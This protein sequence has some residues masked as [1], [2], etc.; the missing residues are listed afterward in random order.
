MNNT[1]YDIDKTFYLQ[2]ILKIV[3]L[4]AVRQCKLRITHIN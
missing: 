2:N 4:K 3:E 1:E